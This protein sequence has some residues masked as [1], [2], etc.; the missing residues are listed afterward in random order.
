LST[1]S[2]AEAAV[3]AASEVPEIDL[4]AVWKDEIA[5]FSEPKADSLD[6]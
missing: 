5:L 4:T 6:L 1:V 3:S 2:S